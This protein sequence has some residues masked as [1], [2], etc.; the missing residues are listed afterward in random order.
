[1]NNLSIKNKLLLLSAMVLIVIFAYSLKI[2]DTAYVSYT[3]G[4]RTYATVELSIKLSS[5]LHEI[6][7]ERGASSGFLSTKGTKFKNILHAQQI[8]T[9]KRIEELKAFYK[10][11]STQEIEIIKKIN[12][13]SI[14][15][16]REKVSSLSVTAKVAL[17]FYT[18]LNK[19]IIDTI[20]YFST[21]PKDVEVRTNFSSF[22]VFISSKEKAGVER[23]VLS[24]VFAIDKFTLN[25]FAKFSSLESEQKTLLN[26]FFNTTSKKIKSEFK[27]LQVN[28]SFKEIERIRKIA[29]SKDRNFNIDS[30]YYFET[31]T[32][33]IE[34]LKEFEDKIAYDIITI[35]KNKANDDI[36][37]LSILTFVTITILLLTLYISYHVTRGITKAYSELEATLSI[38]D[39]NIIFSK[40]DL[41][42]IITHASEAFVQISG[43]TKDELLGK[44]H[45][46]I[47]HPDM[48]KSTFKD[49]WGTIKSGKPWKGNVKNLKKD[50][51]YY[52]VDALIEPIFDD[53][54]KVVSYTATRINTTDKVELETLTKN[55]ELIITEQTELANTQ[56]DKALESAKAKGEFLANM[57]HEIRTPLNAIMGF[58]DLLKEE[59]IGGKS[60]K[61]IDVIS[62]SSKNLLNIIE[63][64]LDFSK[65]ESRKLDIDKVDFNTKAEF[66]VITHLFDAK[67]S[68]K[69]ISL[70]LILDKN[71]PHAINTDPL[72]IKQIITNLIS[73]AV[74]FT[75]DGKNI[76]VKIDYTHNK[77]N[78]S[79]KD[80]GKGIAKDKLL[81]IFEAFS[82]EDSS[83][84]RKYGGTG[85]G[86]SISSELV[87]LLGGELKL[88][89]EVGKGS[90]FYFSI[91][92]TIGKELKS[93][94]IIA[95]EVD[96]KDKK[97]LLVEDNKA[98]QMFM[99]V[100]LE[101]IKI[102]YDI[103][104]DGVEAVEQFKKSKYDAILMDE[105]M[106]NMNGIE[107]TRQI[108]EYE[109][110]N[111]L[112]HTPI[113]ALTANAL[114]GD[115]ERFIEAGLDEY[116]TKP[117]NKEKLIEVFTKLLVDIH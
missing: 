11:Y 1:M 10:V 79:V 101:K 20:S 57:S 35:A 107:A 82:Q 111:Q 91:P 70:S 116:L 51:G 71:L 54:N 36:K 110:L 74:K 19:N 26:L 58:I 85:L 25:S 92:V 109:K 106:P 48:P 49:M 60:E 15:E 95:K 72:R 96:F 12:F 100:I 3:N 5:V 34:K 63:D 104:N 46:I 61:Y 14:K 38:M 41:K 66:E 4:N 68:V 67:C 93:E 69:N 33:K 21:I 16:I 42:G 97:I 45:N 32:K 114:K 75:P 90:E 39:E 64:I 102:F 62:D 22:V 59:N 115:R 9:N 52:W 13:D 103:S 31:M 86:L 55:Q 24:A 28:Q 43:Y 8:Q 88:K 18:L 76:I 23:A 83:T 113:I 65:I 37:T 89:S 40:T 27:K 80:E 84:T 73:N 78:V 2:A 44:S 98:N 112:T 7:K 56:R 94:L 87:K 53:N 17:D 6:Q 81:H 117:V 29:F 77:L 105:N 99:K 47:R 108:L 50:G 30:V